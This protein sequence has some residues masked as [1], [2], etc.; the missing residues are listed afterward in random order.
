MSQFN[1]LTA[2][3]VMLTEE[4][5]ALTVDEGE[6]LPTAP[7]YPRVMRRCLGCDHAYN[8]APVLCR[9][10]ADIRERRR[11]PQSKKRRKS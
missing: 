6:D 11:L 5:V 10:V 1:L 7:G 2:W 3:V 9:L 4:S 8:R